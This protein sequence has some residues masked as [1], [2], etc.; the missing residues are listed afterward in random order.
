MFTINCVIH[1]QY[2]VAKNLNLRL[3]DS[4]NL[5][6]KAVNKIKRHALPSRLFKQLCNDNDEV[7]DKLVMQ[8]EVKWLSKET[9]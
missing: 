1:R 4:L 3:N 2:L 6:I 8:T 7:F 9:V 5:V